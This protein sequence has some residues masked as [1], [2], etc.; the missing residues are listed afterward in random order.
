MISNGQPTPDH[1]FD[2]SMV[3]RKRAIT[4]LICENNGPS[5]GINTTNQLTLL[6][7]SSFQVNSDDTRDSSSSFTSW[8]PLQLA[9]TCYPW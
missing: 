2:D 6:H 3:G 4:L 9:F 7:L 8:R 5:I 1:N